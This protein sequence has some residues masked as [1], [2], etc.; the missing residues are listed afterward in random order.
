MS[1]FKR[2][3]LDERSKIAS[4]IEWACGMDRHPF[5]YV[6]AK[7]EDNILAPSTFRRN[8]DVEFGLRL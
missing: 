2:L 8:G 6:S 4:R 5:E 7:Y 1:K 3:Q